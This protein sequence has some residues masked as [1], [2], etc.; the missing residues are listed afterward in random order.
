MAEIT[1]N[2]TSPKWKF[3]YKIKIEN[4][5]ENP[6]RWL[7]P[8]LSIIAVVPLLC[9][10][11]LMDNQSIFDQLVIFIHSAIESE[12]PEPREFNDETEARLRLVYRE[13]RDALNLP[14]PFSDEPPDIS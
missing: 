11:V 13:L 10:I 14:D 7:S 6:P 5:V 12:Q 8:V 1:N 9:Y 4:R 3:P 2:E